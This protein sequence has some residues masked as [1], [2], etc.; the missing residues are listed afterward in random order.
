MSTLQ[1]LMLA[2]AVVVAVGAAQSLMTLSSLK[3]LGEKISFVATKPIA[4]VDN[5]RAAW[6]AYRD[7]QAYLANFLELT[8]PQESKEAIAAF[9]SQIKALETHLAR[10]GEAVTSAEAG[11]KLQALKADVANWREKAL[12]L[13]GASPAISVPASFAL[14]RIEVAIRNNLDGLVT[15]ALQDAGAMRADVEVSIS[16]AMDL[17]LLFIALGVLAGAALALVSALMITR[18]LLRLEGAMR[19][20]AAGDLEVEVTDGGRKDEIGRM[21]AALDVFRANAVEMRRL[22]MQGREN[23]KITADERRRLMEDVASRFKNQVAGIV[24]RVFGTVSIVEQSAERMLSLANETSKRADRVVGES[25]SATGSIGSVAAAAEEMAATSGEIADRSGQSHQAASEAV[26]KVDSSGK[27]IASLTEATDKIG[28]IVDLIR[29]IAAQTNLLA[30]NATIEAAR[31]GEA[32]RGFSV[33]ASEVKTLA[34]QTSKATG[35]IS[36]QIAHVQ[37]TTRQAAEVIGAVQQTMRMMDT[38]AGEVAAAIDSQKLAITEISQN[39]N[40]AS[41]SAVQ[42]SAEL[43][44]LHKT[45]AQVGEAS[46]DIRAKVTSLGQDAQALRMQTDSF[47]RDILAA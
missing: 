37:E 24:E 30:L 44:A 46:G 42:V 31:A 26:V 41:D 4:G 12:V 45:F 33:V 3:H 35:E 23:E 17:S 25:D 7:V 9:E 10:L 38:V 13:L 14:A 28:E 22:E 5:A 29:D 18:P 1:R 16:R 20:L 47:L 15:L 32:G 19:R 36:N 21:A 39:T 34:D 40:R 8:R 27:V 6:S 2:F 11:E 43:Q